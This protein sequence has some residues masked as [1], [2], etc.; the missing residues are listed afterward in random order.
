MKTV[1]I[2]ITI[3]GFATLMGCN[4]KVDTTAILENQETKTEIFNAIANNHGL[5]TEFMENMQNSEH[6][7]QMMQMMQGNN[8]MMGNMMQGGGMQMIRKTV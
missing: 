3:I 5:M 4:Q 2:Y 6:V 7:M 8:K 1:T